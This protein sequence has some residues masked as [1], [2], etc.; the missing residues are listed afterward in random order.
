MGA[1]VIIVIGDEKNYMCTVIKIERKKERTACKSLN[2]NFNLA[3]F[4]DMAGIISTDILILRPFQENPS[5]STSIKT[6]Q[7]FSVQNYYHKVL[8]HSPR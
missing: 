3:K 6:K 4:S 2:N 7:C 1:E 8:H 5:H